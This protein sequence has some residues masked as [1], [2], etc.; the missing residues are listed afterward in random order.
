MNLKK[1]LIKDC[2]HLRFYRFDRFWWC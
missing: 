1:E 2:K